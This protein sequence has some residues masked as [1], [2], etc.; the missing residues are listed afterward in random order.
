[1]GTGFAI[2]FAASAYQLYVHT[3]MFVGRQIKL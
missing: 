1:M 2:P 3:I